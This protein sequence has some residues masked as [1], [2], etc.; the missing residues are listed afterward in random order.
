MIKAVVGAVVFTAAIAGAL[1]GQSGPIP[2]AQA[3]EIVAAGR[4]DT[5]I[6]PTSAAFTVS[7]TTRAATA[8]QAA[9]ENAKRLA[10]TLGWLRSQG[11]AATDIT[12][13]GYSV[14]QHFEEERGRPTPA[15]FIARNTLRVEVR[16]LDDLGKIIDAALTGGATEISTP[17]FLST[18]LPE[19]RRAALA[20]AVREARADAEAIARAAGGSIGRL[21][22]AN[23][24]VS[25]PMVREAYD[26][27]VLQ[28]RMAGGIPTNI[29]P[30]DLG[31]SAQVTVRWE[32]IPGATR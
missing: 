10:S 1:A 23:S 4:G 11:L 24:G 28:A 31:V 8:A 25:G 20:E 17:Q 12:T 29:M 3:P 26:G 18:N 2:N 21:I 22:S 15:G 14:G 30:R 16:R 32:F 9:S 7:V 5:T 13:A 6:A 27:M 19:G